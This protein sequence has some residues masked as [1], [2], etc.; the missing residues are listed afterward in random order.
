MGA[1]ARA[2][3]DVRFRSVN[4]GS[5]SGSSKGRA[6]R[7]LPPFFGR[8]FCVRREASHYRGGAALLC[9]KRSFA[10]PDQG[11]GGTPIPPFSVCEEELRT[12]AAP[13]GLFRAGEGC[14]RSGAV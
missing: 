5:V 13:G 3:V 8:G 7:P 10:L 14:R 11:T 6:G 2:I 12:T 4:F 9:A 1:H